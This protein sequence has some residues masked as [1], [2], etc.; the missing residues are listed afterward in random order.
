MDRAAVRVD[1]VPVLAIRLQQRHRKAIM[2]A[3]LRHLIML[4]AAAA[5]LRLEA[6]AH[7]QRH[8][9]KAA[10]ELHPQYQDLP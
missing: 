8:M 2:A 1:M 9:E 6:L 5:R 4:A 3:L 10:M 7:L